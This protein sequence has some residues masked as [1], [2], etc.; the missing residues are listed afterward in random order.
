MFTLNNLTRSFI[1]ASSTDLLLKT[2][3]II[4]MN[5]FKNVAISRKQKETTVRMFLFVHFYRP[6][7]KL[8][9]GYVFTGVCDSVHRGACMRGCR[10]AC[11]VAGGCVWLLPGGRGMH[12]CSGGCV[13]APGGMRGCS[14]G[15]HRCYGGHAWLLLGGHAWLLSGGASVVAP[16]GHTWLLW[17]A[18]VV[19]LGGACVVAAA[20]HAWW[21]WGAC[22]VALGGVWL[23]PG[24][25]VWL[26]L[27]GICGCS[28]GGA[29]DTTR[30]RDT[31][32]ERAIRILLECILVS[33]F[34]TLRSLHS[35]E[36]EIIHF[37]RNSKFL[38]GQIK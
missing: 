37:N 18:C 6:L 23:L 13:V 17:G 14:W 11:M 26:L 5:A 22:M 21:L 12:G 35:L 36:L 3:E 20:G 38:D 24:V 32:N 1:K 31:I 27:G 33:H 34:F 2:Q 30:Y 15:V 28:L 25:H 4:F 7:T 9:E 10:G 19:A 16:G 8:R 29:W